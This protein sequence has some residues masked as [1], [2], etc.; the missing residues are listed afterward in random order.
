MVVE[1]LKDGG[2]VVRQALAHIFND[3]LLKDMMPPEEW[4]ES[5]IIVL[6]KKGDQHKP[7]NYRP[8][9]LLP[10]M[11]NIFSR[12]LQQRIKAVLQEAQSCDQAGFRTGL[13]CADHL[14]TAVQLVEKMK[15]F[16]KAVVDMCSGF[17]KGI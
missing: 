1:L 3:I 12:L 14:F 17:Q 2:R 8:I 10:I 9:T 5:R 6:F 15:E 4:K 7:E 11:Y 16:Q 13:S